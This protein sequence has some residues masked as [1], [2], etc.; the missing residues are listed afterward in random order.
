MNHDLRPLNANDAAELRAQGGEIY[1]ADTKDYF[2]CRQC[3]RDAEIGE[4]LILVSYDPFE[5]DSPY[6]SASPIFLH[7][8]DCG[9]SNIETGAVPRQMAI[10]TLSVRSFDANAMMIDAK[11][12]PGSELAA[13]IDAMFG[14]PASTYLHVHNA[15]RGCFAVAVDRAQ[16]APSV[17]DF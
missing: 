14:D 2:P 9:G 13:T 3:L 1:L 8:H 17:N 12:A 16:P 7:L 6:R 15:E 5:R 10:R 11:V 4:E